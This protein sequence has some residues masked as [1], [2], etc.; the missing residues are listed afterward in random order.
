MSVIC[1]ESL[2]GHTSLR[3]KHDTTSKIK[4]F[5]NECKKKKGDTKCTITHE[6]TKHQLH[7]DK[8]KPQRWRI[9]LLLPVNK[10]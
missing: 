10:A 5:M 6:R 1:V 8:N 2:T 9:E 7:C 4:C 3:Q